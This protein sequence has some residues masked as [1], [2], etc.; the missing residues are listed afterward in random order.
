MK[1]IGIFTLLL[2]IG[3]KGF[4]QTSADSVKIDSVYI[5]EEIK[6]DSVFVPVSDS[7]VNFAISTKDTLAPVIFKPVVNPI[8][9]QVISRFKAFLAQYRQ[10][11]QIRS[12]RWDDIFIPHAPAWIRSNPDYYKLAMPATYYSAAIEQAM[13]IEDWEPKN[14]Y[15]M[16]SPVC[17]SVFQVPR[18]THTADVDRAVN[19]QLLSFY[20][21]YPNLVR[22]N[23]NDLKGLEPLSDKMIIRKPRKNKVLPLLTPE[24]ERPMSGKDLLVIK[25]NFWTISGNGYM[26]FSQNYISDNWYKGG[27]STV[28]HYSP[29]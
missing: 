23:E 7:L 25:P 8:N 11:R 5:T 12:D 6:N 17:D 14:P 20:L 4:A 9:A 15:I 27:E 13:S 19:K 21:Q 1:T 3:V 10:E 2:L 18:L 22:K 28:S 29:L 16:E 26:Q 24:R